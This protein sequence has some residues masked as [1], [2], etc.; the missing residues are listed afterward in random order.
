MLSTIALVGA[1]VSVACSSRHP[2]PKTWPTLM[3]G[4]KDCQHLAG[5]YRD[6][7]TPSSFASSSLTLLLFSSEGRRNADSVRIG[8][9]EPGRL[10][11]DLVTDAGDSTSIVL[12]SD[13]KQFACDDGLLTIKA[14]GQW[15]GDVNQLGF[16]IGKR[17][18]ALEL[19][20]ADGYLVVKQKARTAGIVY[21]FPY[22]YVQDEWHRFERLVP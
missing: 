13:R 18:A 2:Y 3:V 4:Q 9:P 14:G 5:R 20:I 8:F 19:R 1:L 22:R 12:S 7:E 16:G 11:I 17:S 21:V 15:V 6:A 10:Q